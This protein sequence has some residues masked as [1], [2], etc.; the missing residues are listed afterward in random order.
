[1]KVTVLIGLFY[2][3]LAIHAFSPQFMETLFIEVFLKNVV[4][5]KMKHSY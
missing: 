2:T 5:L 1:M 3:T 4:L